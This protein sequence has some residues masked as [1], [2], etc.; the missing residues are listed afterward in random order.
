MVEMEIDVSVKVCCGYKHT[1]VL[2]NKGKIYAWG[3]N[4]YGQIG[5]NKDYNELQRSGPIMVTRGLLMK[6][7]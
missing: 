5:V 6:S 1:L 7:F 2:T 3:D 4:N